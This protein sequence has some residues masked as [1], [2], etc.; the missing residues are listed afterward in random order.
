MSLSYHEI[1][2]PLFDGA[3]TAFND[4]KDGIWNAV[5][6]VVITQLKQIAVAISDIAAGLVAD[7]PYYTAE[8]AKI[9]IGMAINAAISTIAAA[10]E[11]IITEVQAAMKQVINDIRDTVTAA[12]GAVLPAL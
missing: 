11:M 8:A 5:Q 9:L 3:E 1:Y 7:P 6:N 10:T 4:V 2:Q 12:I